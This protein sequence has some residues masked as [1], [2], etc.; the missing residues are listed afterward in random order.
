MKSAVLAKIQE[1]IRMN[2]KEFFLGS[3]SRME[4]HLSGFAEEFNQWI[5]SE[6]IGFSVKPKQGQVIVLTKDEDGACQLLRFFLIGNDWQV[7]VDLTS[8]TVEGMA[9]QL[10]EYND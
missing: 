2:A 3:E 5:G 1:E 4:L 10:L 9:I 8:D 6:P 7:S